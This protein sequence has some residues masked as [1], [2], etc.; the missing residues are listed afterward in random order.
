MLVRSNSHDEKEDMGNQTYRYQGSVVSLDG[1]WKNSREG[2]AAGKDIPT[3]IM[4]FEEDIAWE[5]NLNEVVR[6]NEKMCGYN[7]NSKRFFIAADTSK[8]N[9]ETSFS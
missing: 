3:T 2:V 7:T 8:K 1:D 5:I 4:M 9:P 6:D